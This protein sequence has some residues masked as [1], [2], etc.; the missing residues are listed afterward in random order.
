MNLTTKYVDNPDDLREV[1]ESWLEE[2]KGEEFGFEI[3]IDGIISDSKNWLATGMGAVI[4]LC[5]NQGRYVGF[6]TVYHVPDFMAVNHV[7]F[8]KY[9]YVMPDFRYGALRMLS[10]AKSWAKEQGA[11][12]LIL[13][14]SAMASDMYNSLCQLYQRYGMKVFEKSYICELE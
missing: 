1:G 13:S 9:W 11:T 2:A 5:D 6:M 3:S 10:E 7:A 8:E 12:N 14:A 4:G